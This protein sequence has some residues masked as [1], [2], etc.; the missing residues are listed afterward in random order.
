MSNASCYAKVAAGVG[1]IAAAGYMASDS[2][3]A[4]IKAGL[5]YLPKPKTP[6]SP[7]PQAVTI[8]HHIKHKSF[9]AALGG[10]IVGAILATVVIAATFALIAATGGLA[11]VAIAA[12][13][14]AAVVGTAYIGSAVT[15]FIDKSLSATDGPVATGSHN[16]FIHGKPAARA[17]IDTVTCVKHSVPSLIAQG[18]ETVA[19]NKMPA[20]RI[21]DKTACDGTIQQGV[22]DVFIGSGQATVVEITPDEFP[23]WQRA[24]LF[25]VDYLIP[26]TGLLVKGS[27]K[28]GIKLAAKSIAKNGVMKSIIGGAKALG[29]GAIKQLKNI[30]GALK[31]AALGACIAF[32]KLKNKAALIR[33]ISGFSG[34]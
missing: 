2:L 28:G 13:G 9:W 32:S 3:M 17:G 24:I 26:P 25:A 20:V 4:G 6:A 15:N 10:A 31:T 16:V 29:R 5:D 34:L 8:G 22:S 1:G 19:I 7:P 27:I 12:I 18:S 11:V 23:L 14:I 33:G 21:G 30:G